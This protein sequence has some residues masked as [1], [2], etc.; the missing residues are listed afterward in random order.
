MPHDF[1]RPPEDF[2]LMWNILLFAVSKRTNTQTLD[3][4]NIKI[5]SLE[6]VELAQAYCEP[7]SVIHHVKFCCLI[8]SYI[9]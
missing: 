4:E 9:I 6:H 2:F 3:A 5:C 8:T 1:Q 7:E